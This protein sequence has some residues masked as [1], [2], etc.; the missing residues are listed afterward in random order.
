MKPNKLVLLSLVCVVAMLA[1]K[2]EKA[3]SASAAAEPL[4]HLKNQEAKA[5]DQ[6]LRPSLRVRSVIQPTTPRAALELSYND[7]QTDDL[8]TTV[9][10]IKKLQLGGMNECQALSEKVSGYTYLNKAKVALSRKANPDALG[11]DEK[12]LLVGA[13]PR[14]TSLLLSSL[15]DPYAVNFLAIRETQDTI[16]KEKLEKQMCLLAE[17]LDPQEYSERWQKYLEWKKSQQS[18]AAKS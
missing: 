18:A 13:G 10:G 12:P 4:V 11:S 1:V 17:N 3:A 15:A 2:T 7:E 5:F 16:V 8:L 14:L 9:A 6:N